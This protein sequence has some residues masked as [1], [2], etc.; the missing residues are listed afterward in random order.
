MSPWKEISLKKSSLCR[1]KAI[2]ISLPWAHSRHQVQCK[3]EVCWQEITVGGG[4]L[5]FQQS[6]T[7]CDSFS[8]FVQ[9]QLRPNIKLLAQ[10]VWRLMCLSS[11]IIC[12]SVIMVDSKSEIPLSL[13]LWQAEIELAT[14][15]PAIHTQ[16]FLIFSLWPHIS[17][18]D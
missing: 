12:L 11:I 1:K 13:N 18:K 3:A 9:C 6:H 14:P 15:A 4:D 2:Y 16:I 5:L 17:Q 10:N 7:C 8:I